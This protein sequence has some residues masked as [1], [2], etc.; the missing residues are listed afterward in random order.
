[1]RTT[2][3]RTSTRFLAAPWLMMVVCMLGCSGGDGLDAAAKATRDRILLSS[4][5][6]SAVSLDAAR[7]AAKTN[8]ELVVTGRITA[9]G[10][11]P[12]V[13]GKAAF[14]IS[15]LPPEEELHSHAPGHDPD[16]CPFCKHKAGKAPMAVVQFLDAEGKILPIDARKLF[17]IKKNQVVVIRGRVEL[18][19]FG[20]MLVKAENMYVKG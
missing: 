4:E 5:P 10:T 7:E 13:T 18:D 8:P 11:E 1:M 3:I 20:A 2:T 9:G 17:G 19:D 6:K 12:W 16:S 15:E 14:V